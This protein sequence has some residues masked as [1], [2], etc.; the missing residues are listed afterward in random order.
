LTQLTHSRG[1]TVASSYTQTLDPTGRRLSVAEN[2][3]RIVNYSYDALYRLTND[4]VAGDPTAASANGAV[5]Y[6]YD[7]VGNRLSRISTLMAVLSATSAYDAND[8]LT[9]D[10]YDANGNTRAANGSTYAYDFENRLKSVNGGSIRVVY[11]GDGN[12][13]SKTVGGVTT[14]Y[15]VDD[16]STTGY[17]QVVEEL[18]GGT[19][20]RV[21]T[22]GN[23]LISQRQ[24]QNGNWQASFYGLDGHGN[25]RFLTDGGGAV[26]DTYSYDAF[27][28]L[29]SSTGSTPNSYLFNGQQYDADLGLY[30]KR[31]RYYSQERGRFMTMDPVAGQINEPMTLH[32]YIFGHADPV[33]RVDPCGTTAALDTGL[34]TNQIALR[35][36]AQ[37]TIVGIRV[38]CLFYRAASVIDPS[39]IPSIPLAFRGCAEDT[40][41]RLRDLCLLNPWQP[42][43]NRKKFGPRKDCGA[44]YRECKHDGGA[45]PFYK[46]PIF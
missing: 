19:V 12:R 27:G 36:A 17:S 1:A 23:H 37:A 40:C 3:G 38:S 26:T 21:Y 30:F 4:T 6:T 9:T 14:R 8:R 13:V 29:T 15:L 34:L 41:A 2:N 44:C 24:Q 25:V 28:I 39:I 5:D 33:N 7:L 43:W 20:E 35:A 46:C 11:D 16:L 31:A 18:V 10:P 45:W 32:R 42:A 22:Y